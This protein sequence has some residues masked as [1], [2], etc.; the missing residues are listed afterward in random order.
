MVNNLKT[1][2]WVTLIVVA[3]LIAFALLQKSIDTAYNR[4]VNVVFSILLFGLVVPLAFRESLRGN[5]I[6]ISNLYWIITSLIGSI[7]LGYFA[8]HQKLAIKDY[9][10]VGL[11]CVAFAVQIFG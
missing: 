10:A 9:A 6:A 2:F 3:E 1:L 4:N 11:V 5:A 8:F 7:L